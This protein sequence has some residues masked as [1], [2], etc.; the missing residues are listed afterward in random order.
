[1]RESAKSIAREIFN[2]LLLL[3]SASALLL[4]ASR[5][6]REIAEL[7]FFGMRTAVTVIIPSVFPFMVLSD[8]IRSTVD[9][10][11]LRRSGAFLRRLIGI[12]GGELC[13]YILGSIAGF[14]VGAIAVRESYLGGDLDRREAERLVAISSVPSLSF[15]V[16][17]V[18][19]AI[20]GS[21][22]VGLALYFSVIASS[23]IYALLTKRAD[24]TVDRTPK[25]RPRWN[26]SRSIDSASKASLGI[27]ATVTLFSVIS[28]LIS[29]CGLP[30]FLNSALLMLLE[31]SSACLQFAENTHASLLATAFSLGFCGLS[32]HIQI[33]GILADTDLRYLP[34]L[35]AKLVMGL[36]TATIFSSLWLF[37]K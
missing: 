23:M 37:I 21:A 29:S 32:V 24:S 28:G 27:I 10:S 12:G 18:G 35:T 3:F 13:A 17:G 33:R 11:A 31:L 6:A 7:G 2:L 19:S 20:H 15:T 4:L 5:W 16:A 9:F 25:G 1:M 30:D 22:A 8:I 26:L 36:I 34:F 14:P